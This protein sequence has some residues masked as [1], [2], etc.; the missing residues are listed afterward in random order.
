MSKSLGVYGNRNQNQN[1]AP[2]G[3]AGGPPVYSTTPANGTASRSG[4]FGGSTNAAPVS[5]YANPPVAS[6]GP[7]YASQPPAGGYAPPS[8]PPPSGGY[9]PPQVAPPPTF[10]AQPGGVAKGSPAPGSYLPPPG[11]PPGN[12]SY[13]PPATKFAPPPGPPPT[14]TSKGYAP[15]AGPPPNVTTS[16]AKVGDDG[17]YA[18]PSMPPP[19]PSYSGADDPSLLPWVSAYAQ[20]VEKINSLT[21]IDAQ[22]AQQSQVVASLTAQVNND[23]RELGALQTQQ[24]KEAKDVQKIDK[25]FSFMSIKAKVSGKYDQVKEKEYAE[26]NQINAAVAAKQNVLNQNAQILAS[27]TAERDRL[28]AQALDLKNTRKSLVHT[29]NKAFENSAATNPNDANLYNSLQQSKTSLIQVDNDL[30]AHKA[31]LSLLGSAVVHLQEALAHIASATDSQ[32]V[33]MFFDN[34]FSEMNTLANSD[35]AQ[36]KAAMA[37][38][39]IRQASM[40][41]PS[42]PGR[43]GDTNI[44]TLDAFLT[45]FVDN[46][47]T[48]LYNLERLRQA[49]IKC[50]QTLTNCIAVT[51]WLSSAVASI[52]SVRDLVITN[53]SQIRKALRDYRMSTFETVVA[54]HGASCGVSVHV[55]LT[56]F[57]SILPNNGVIEEAAVGGAVA[58]SG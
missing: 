44:G 31:A 5:G 33:D 50:R 22:L 36:R 58:L 9:L 34:P 2:T 6:A 41:I 23:R 32:Q 45:I 48:D 52:S 35:D 10:Y 42:L 13:A 17:S 15:P 3:Q 11:P 40:Y 43:L 46:I 27:A 24:A 12:S 21:S 1:G 29:L 37:G 28:A 26:L 55:A 53:V 51:S 56:N 20:L 7:I 38:Q 18:A 8:Q 16:N 57:D 49:E 54:K 25:G 4:F 19:P 39:L 47:F 14:T 30:K